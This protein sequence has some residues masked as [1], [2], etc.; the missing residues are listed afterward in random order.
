MVFTQPTKKAIDYLF[1][2]IK[3]DKVNRKF[4]LFAKSFR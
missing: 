1:S 4:S 2:A 3:C